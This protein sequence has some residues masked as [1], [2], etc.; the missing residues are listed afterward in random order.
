MLPNQMPL[1]V[2]ALSGLSVA[3]PPP[4]HAQSTKPT[5]TS[6]KP[7]VVFI[8]MHN[9][10]GAISA[11]TA[12]LPRR[13]ALESKQVSR[14]EEIPERAFRPL[15]RVFRGLYTQESRVHNLCVQC[16]MDQSDRRLGT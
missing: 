9:F 4:S 15:E 3:V 2:L 5:D 16:W 11:H 13:H 12:G 6:K 1:S 8:L 7:N 14:A 10:G